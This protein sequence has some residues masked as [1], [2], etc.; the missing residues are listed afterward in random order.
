MRRHRNNPLVNSIASQL[1]RVDK[2]GET[3]PSQHL[4]APRRSADKGETNRNISM[5]RYFLI[6]WWFFKVFYVE[7]Q[8]N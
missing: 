5:T 4:P 2:S 3:S 1:S 6:F 8:I 7:T